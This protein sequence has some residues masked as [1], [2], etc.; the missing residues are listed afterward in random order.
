M[1]R[2]VG[3]REERNDK[4]FRERARLPFGCRTTLSADEA[5]PEGD[6]ERMLKGLKIDW[7]AEEREAKTH[8]SDET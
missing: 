6:Q 4:W 8:S 3:S 5:T 7:G 2:V 1:S